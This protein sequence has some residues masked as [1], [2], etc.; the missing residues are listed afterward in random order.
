MTDSRERLGTP[1][2]Q[3]PDAA[4]R[5]TDPARDPGEPAVVE[6][7][8]IGRKRVRQ[9]DRAEATAPRLKLVE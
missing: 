5:I 2:D 4:G 1:A 8:Q 6:L 9:S 7:H 3:T